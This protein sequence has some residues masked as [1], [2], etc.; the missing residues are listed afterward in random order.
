M[1]EE[2]VCQGSDCYEHR[3]RVANAETKNEEKEN[4]DQG[5]QELTRKTTKKME[6]EAFLQLHYYEHGETDANDE[7]NEHQGG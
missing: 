1:A 5:K 6:E 7:E 4:E 3:A 2:E